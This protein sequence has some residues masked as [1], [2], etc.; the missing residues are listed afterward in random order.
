MT[1]LIVNERGNF[2]YMK[3]FQALLLILHCLSIYNQMIELYPPCE[4]KADKVDLYRR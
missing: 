2:V 4:C 3:C 1:S